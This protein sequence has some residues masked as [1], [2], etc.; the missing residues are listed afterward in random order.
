MSCEQ[1]T[2]QAAGTPC[3]RYLASPSLMTFRDTRCERAMRRRAE[4]QASPS[5]RGR[6][7]CRRSQGRRAGRRGVRRCCGAAAAHKVQSVKK[8]SAAQLTALSPTKTC[9][10]PGQRREQVNK[11]AS[12]IAAAK[13]HRTCSARLLSPTSTAKHDCHT[14]QMN[15]AVRRRRGACPL[16]R[17]GTGGEGQRRAL[18]PAR[19]SSDLQEQRNV[20]LHEPARGARE[21]RNATSS[22]NAPGKNA[23][24]AK[25]C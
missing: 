4:N 20:T 1:S 2:D 22:A 9:S 7:S 15:A 14:T 3:T 12:L 10:S 11:L 5:A 8:A 13:A 19:V 18:A 25:T 24:A 17:R 16:C 23:G 6:W 21:A